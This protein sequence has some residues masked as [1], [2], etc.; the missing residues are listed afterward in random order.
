MAQSILLK[1]SSVAGN[2]PG[3]SDLALGEIAINTADG[4]VYIKKGNNDIVAVADNDILHIDT[5][6]GQVGIGTTSPSYRLHVDSGTNDWPALF[7]STDAKAGIIIQ[8]T[9]TTNYLISQSYTLSIGNQAS[10]HASNLNIKS[11]GR[12][13]IGITSPDAMLHIEDSSSSAYGGL[14]VVGA[15]TGSGSTNV[16]QIADFGRTNS[17]SVSGVWLGGRTDETTAVIGA[18]TASGNIAFEV[19][20]SGWQERMRITNAGAVGIGTSSPARKFVVRDSGAQMSLLSDTDGSSVINFGDTAD[21]NA[22]RIHYNNDTDAMFIRTAT[23][24]RIT[25]LSS[26]NVGIGT[27]SP[28]EKLE[29]SGGHLKVTN[30][31]N[32]N[33]YINANAVGSDATIYF[34]ED[35][36]IKAKIQH[37]ASNDS[38]L[39]TD[40]AYTDTMT[41]K[42]AKVGIGTTNPTAPLDVHGMLR[43]QESSNTA[44]YSGNYV[45]VFSDQSYGF[46]NSGGTT[47]AQISMNGNS[48]FNGGNVGIG[49]ASPGYNFQV[50]GSGDTIASVVAGNSSVAGF[51]MGSSGTPADGGIRYDNS[52]DKLI[53]RAG[54]ATKAELSSTG[55]LTL[56]SAYTFPT[57]DGSANQVLKTDGSGNLTFAT[58]AGASGGT[59]I[60]DSDGDTKIQVEESSDEDKIRFDTAG[61][62]RMLLDNTGNVGIGTNTPGYKLDVGGSVR[63][64]GSASLVGTLQSYSG[65]FNVKNIAQDQDLNLQVNDGGTNTTALTVQGTT[66]NV[67]IGTSSPGTKLDVTTVA[68]TAGI[69]VTAPNTTSQ[70]FGAT[71]AAGTNS[72][73]YAFNINNAAGTGIL[74]VLGSGNIG[75]NTT[76]PTQGLQISSKNLYMQAG[77]ILMSQGTAYFMNASNGALKHGF[78]STGYGFEGMNVGIGTTTPASLLSIQGDGVVSRM[79]GTANTSRTLLFRN[80]GTAEGIVQTDGNMHF[81]Q[82]DASRY[83][84]F[85]TANTE[86]MRIDANGYLLVGKTN[87]TFTTVGTEIRGGNL[88]ARIIRSNAEPLVLHRTGSNGPILNFYDQSTHVGSISSQ[89]SDNLYISGNAANHAGLKFGTQT[90]IPMVQTAQ[91]DNT[92]NLGTTS[93]RFHDAHFGGTVN[94]GENLV[95]TGNL[96]INGT[97]TTLN[98]ATLNVEDKN[99]TLNKG[100]GDTSGSA[101]GAGITIQDAVDA[102]TD[103]TLTWN[104]STDSF[105]TSHSFNV[106]GNISLTNDLVY[107]ANTNF[108]I[109]QPFASQNITFHTTPSG[110]SATERMRIKH[111]GYVGIG[112]SNPMEKLDVHGN[113]RAERFVVDS[114]G[115]MLRKVNDTWTSGNQLHD[116]LYNGWTSSTGDYTYV[117]AAGNGTTAHGILQVGDLG[118]WIGQTDLEQGALADSN[119]API[120][121]VFAFFRGDKSYVKGS[122]GIGTTSP[123]FALDVQTASGNT[124]ARFKDSDSSHSGI[125]IAGDTNAGWV[126]NDVGVTGEGIYYQSSNNLMRFYTNSAERIRILSDGKVGIGTASPDSKLTVNVTS[127]GDGIELQSSEVTIATLDRT[128]VGGQVVASLDGVASRPIHIGGVINEDVILANAGGNVGIGTTSPTEKL[129]FNVLS[130]TTESIFFEDNSS[131]NYG[132]KLRYIESTNKFQIQGLESG[133]QTS[134]FNINRSDGRVGI[135]TDSPQDRL[136]IH[137][138]S[139]SANLGL[140]ITRGSQTHGLRLGVNDSHA[141]LWTSENQNIAFGTSGTQRMTVLSGG[142]V[143]INTATARTTGGTARLTIADS[144]SCISMGPSN[145]DLMYIR[146]IGAGQFQMQTYNNNNIGNLELQPYGG[147]VGIGTGSSTNPQAT[148]QVEEYG[149]DTTSTASSATTQI[150]IHSFAAATFRSARFTVQV[151]NST[152]STYHTTELLLVHNGTTAN[153]TEF[154]EIH[155]GSAVEATFD[156]DINS[157]NV[158]LLATPATTDTMAFKVVCHSITT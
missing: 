64:S 44:F 85:S 63:F 158:R 154:G 89:D 152:D 113:A 153:I 67:G 32:A 135:G 77:S 151:T 60:S 114:S 131:G 37:D 106:I 73:D 25:I 69:R 155:T 11:T 140:K 40:G 86:R 30:A 58:V 33:I 79:D 80:V 66:A 138:S 137:D 148:F 109:K 24:D 93:A 111:D 136:N 149:I 14:R 29:V 146:R 39:F 75:I 23:V 98:T 22:G 36:G 124:L 88:G 21:D 41:L 19:Y 45:R 10:L 31:G 94:V 101:D 99:I 96:T 95:V 108:D 156:A 118:T 42:S 48:Y 52:A 130:N 120:D 142:Q 117:K 100:S 8:D 57:A 92:V 107:N 132:F 55:A 141:F 121:N 12:V 65:A 53:F 97:S 35:D 50:V 127:N 26:G 17:G 84:R 5:S 56:N 71:I 83:M 81:L 16:R 157:G 133:S 116:V 20:N 51:N 1:R 126:G 87:T 145:S 15:G 72:S 54:N 103:A 150:A 91:S 119:T 90:L 70:S 144:A 129:Q 112:T 28:S 122:L 9:N 78:H 105:N 49:T 27:T 13:G 47:K 76:V 128:I 68:N 125:V 104:A 34:E 59:S 43:V 139:S 4:A 115:A 38:M 46:R 147:K 62:Q 143:G 123:S 102:S 74:R 61:T 18:K 110:G 2:V 7:K 134:M 6:N 3:S 82:E